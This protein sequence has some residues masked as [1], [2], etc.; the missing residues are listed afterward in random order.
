MCSQKGLE[1]LVKNAG[2]AAFQV[3]IF[4]PVAGFSMV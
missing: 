3:G 4:T 1:K 2:S